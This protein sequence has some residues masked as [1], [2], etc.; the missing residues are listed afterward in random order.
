MK[1]LEKVKLFLLDLDGTV[2]VADKLIDGA[3]E[4][5]ESLEKRGKVCY[6][7]NNS[8]KGRSDYIKSLSALGLNANEWNIYT[9][10]DAAARYILLHYPGKKVYCV[11]TPALQAQLC[12][13]GIALTEDNPDVALLG[14]DTTLTYEKLY[15][16]CRFIKGGVPYI[17]TH[18]DV[19][20]PFSPVD[21]PDVGSIAQ[22]IAASVG[23]M[24][25]FVCG[26]PSEFLGECL[27]EKYNLS[28]REIAMV[29]DRMETDIKFGLNNGMV[30]VLVLSGAT[31]KDSLSDYGYSPDYVFRN[32]SELADCLRRGE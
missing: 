30:S 14:F 7:T 15:K 27:C 23:K 13:Y 5:I 19:N 25:E 9:S 8:S 20:C 17:A 4:A 2:Y 1:K 18:M 21:M 11:G 24:P 16:L 26:K 28:A 31:S 29:G 6:L 12:G 3:K 10:G 22:T 32:I